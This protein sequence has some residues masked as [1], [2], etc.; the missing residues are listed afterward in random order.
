MTVQDYLQVGLG[1]IL[2]V[3]LLQALIRNGGRQYILL[4]L[5]VCSQFLGTV[6]HAS[7]VM[8]GTWSN[9]AKQYFWASEITQNLLV[10][11]T[12]ITFIYNRLGR[13]DSTL[14]LGRWLILLAIAGAGLSL[15]IHSDIRVN[16]W[17][18]SVTRDMTFIATFLNL[19]LWGALLK[20]RDR[21]R[22]M[23]VSGGLGVQLA[24]YSMGQALRVLWE[25]S[26]TL[27]WIGDRVIVFSYLISLLILYKAFRHAE[28]TLPGSKPRPDP[29]KSG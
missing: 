20:N 11:A 22:L 6:L 2:Q 14:R 5:L 4:T 13:S 27:I 25:R 1:F 8:S 21:D 23:M 17:M 7:I 10:F 19:I 28:Y 3:L 12:I 16:L 9:T 24:G 29:P 15:W 18:S 26:S